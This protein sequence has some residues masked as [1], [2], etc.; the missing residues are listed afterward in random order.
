MIDKEKNNTRLSVK[1]IN[2]LI[3][4]KNWKITD[5]VSQYDL[6]Y[7]TA[8]HY[9]DKRDLPIDLAIRVCEDFNISMDYIYRY[10]L[11]HEKLRKR[12]PYYIKEQSSIET[13]GPNEEYSKPKLTKEQ[14]REV[15]A[16]TSKDPFKAAMKM[17]LEEIMEEKE[18]KDKSSKAS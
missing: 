5:F 15:M 18:K 11:T 12:D 3:N 7:Q 8:R 6:K 4:Y 10:E 16:L 14:K 9:F 13:G 2:C 17:L 1:N